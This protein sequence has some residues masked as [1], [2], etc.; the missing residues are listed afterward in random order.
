MFENR[1]KYHL[2]NKVSLSCSHWLEMRG[3]RLKLAL[4]VKGMSEGQPDEMKKMMTN[5]AESLVDLEEYRQ[6]MVFVK[7]TKAWKLNRI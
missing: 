1:A 3:R 4:A 2:Q 5:V 7:R 6:Y